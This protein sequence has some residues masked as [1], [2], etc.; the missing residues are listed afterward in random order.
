VFQASAGVK[1]THVIYAG[2]APIYQDLL[3]GNIDFTIG[4][5]PP[6]PDAL[7]VM[8]PA[9]TRRHPLYPN[10]PTLAE[11]GAENAYDSWFGVV[12]PPSLPKPIADRLITELGAVYKDPEA[13]AKFQSATK[14][15][16]EANPLTGDEFKKGVLEE[17]AKWKI[18]AEREKIVL[19]Q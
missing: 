5:T 9:G 1:G 6:F 8:G 14:S 7:K 19:Q 3:G 17:Q 16:P 4:A 12:A 13:I 15:E 10:L 2:V 11:I 18:V